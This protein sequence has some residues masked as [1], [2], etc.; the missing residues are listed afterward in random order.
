MYILSP[1]GETVYII[2]GV[3]IIK[4]TKL[5]NNMVSLLFLKIINRF[6]VYEKLDLELSNTS[7][8]VARTQ[9]WP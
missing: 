5:S 2:P 7:V 8:Q 4:S 1:A 3:N 6:E 9:I